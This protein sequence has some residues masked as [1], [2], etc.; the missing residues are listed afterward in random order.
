MF[1]RYEPVTMSGEMRILHFE[2]RRTW[3]EFRSFLDGL[4]MGGSFG[5]EI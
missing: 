5:R 1:R 4:E 3:L 2:S